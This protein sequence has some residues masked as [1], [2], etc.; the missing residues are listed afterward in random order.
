M[1]LLRQVPNRSRKLAIPITEELEQRLESIKRR[2]QEQHMELPFQD[3]FEAFLAKLLDEAE[4]E[5]DG[6]SPAPRRRAVR[7]A[8][9]VRN[10]AAGERSASPPAPIPM[11]NGQAMPG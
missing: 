9:T 7:P 5:L 6:T 3:A 11:S 10:D 4:A 8:S 2:C 1:G